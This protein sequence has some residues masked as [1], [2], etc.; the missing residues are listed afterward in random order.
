MNIDRALKEAVT[1]EVPRIKRASLWGKMAN[2]L[3]VGAAPVILKRV[4]EGINRSGALR[5]RPLRSDSDD[6]FGISTLAS[7]LVEVDWDD[8]KDTFVSSGESASPKRAEAIAIA[9]AIE[10]LGYFFWKNWFASPEDA[11]HPSTSGCSF[12]TNALEATFNALC[13]LLERDMILTRWYSD[14]PLPYWPGSAY[15]ELRGLDAALAEEGGVLRC[16]HFVDG[17]YKCH[18]VTL[19]AHYPDLAGQDRTSFYCGLGGGPRL[20]PALEQAVKELVRFVRVYHGREIDHRART[21]SRDVN[22]ATR[23]LWMYQDPEAQELYLQRCEAQS[24]GFPESSWVGTDFDWVTEL[25]SLEFELQPFPTLRCIENVGVCV[26][27]TNPLLQQLDFEETPI[28]NS[29]RIENV[30]GR[31]TKIVPR[32]HFI[33]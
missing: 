22:D 1:L 23:R 7:K 18:S 27:V 15:P 28:I 32:P 2:R 29:E 9:E 13:E 17:R 33:P 3:F 24:T 5:V 12:H 26:R 25:L 11:E 8:R 21:K 4:Q 19:T 20:G 10:R 31:S 6:A 16:H 14:S 30:L